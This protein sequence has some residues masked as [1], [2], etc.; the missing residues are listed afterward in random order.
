MAPDLADDPAHPTGIA[1]S[2]TSGA[3]FSGLSLLASP[4]AV[5]PAWGWVGHRAAEQPATGLQ[6]TQEEDSNE[7]AAA[8]CRTAVGP[9]SNAGAM[10]PR[11]SATHR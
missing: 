5:P 7:D 9:C 10:N 6:K 4:A 8:D 11:S 1:R 3:R 2:A